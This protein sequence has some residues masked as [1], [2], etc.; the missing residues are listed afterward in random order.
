[1]TSLSDFT[2]EPWRAAARAR[3]RRLPRADELDARLPLEVPI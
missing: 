2:N 3:A 1:M